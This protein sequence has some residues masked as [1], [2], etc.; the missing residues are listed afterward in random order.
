M[1]QFK[2]PKEEIV[3]LIPN[4]GGAFATDHITVEGKPLS[5][6]YREEPDNEMDSGWRFF[7]GEETQDYVDDS[8]NT[9]I[10]EVNTIANYEPAIIELLN[11]P[12]PCAFERIEGTNQ[13]MEVD[14]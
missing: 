13:F 4:M 10:Y 3:R 6:M 5:Y 1:K 8:S 7:S 11:T 12:Y 14:D 9:S 2:I